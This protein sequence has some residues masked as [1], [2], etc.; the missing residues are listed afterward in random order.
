MLLVPAAVLANDVEIVCSK[1]IKM[2]SISLLFLIIFLNPR[3]DENF[4]IYPWTLLLV[5]VSWI[6][7]DD[8]EV[9]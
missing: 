6:S 8:V 7:T 5:F 1:V 3:V 4:E 9:F 2:G